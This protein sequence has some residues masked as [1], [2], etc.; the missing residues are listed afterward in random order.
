VINRY[1]SFIVKRN[2]VFHNELPKIHFFNT[3]FYYYLYTEF[4]TNDGSKIDIFSGIKYLF[5]PIHITKPYEHWT[6]VVVN[7][8]LNEISYYDSLLKKNDF[9]TNLIKR[10]LVG[11]NF[12]F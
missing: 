12:L 4:S 2:I 10:F 11:N 1:L 8:Y 5:I 3:Y 9:C 7:F 6:L